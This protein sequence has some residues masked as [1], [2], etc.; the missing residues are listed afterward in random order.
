MH[1]AAS[2][3]DVSDPSLVVDWVFLKSFAC[4]RVVCMSVLW[5]VALSG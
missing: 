2:A 1:E 5:A 4:P 3:A